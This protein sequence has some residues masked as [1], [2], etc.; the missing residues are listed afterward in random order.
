MQAYHGE[1]VTDARLIGDSMVEFTVGH[2]RF[3][4][5]PHRGRLYLGATGR[6]CHQAADGT[7]CFDSFTTARTVSAYM[8]LL[9]A[10]IQLVA[11]DP[12]RMDEYRRAR[13]QS[14]GGNP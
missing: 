11:R 3:R 9:G 4:Y 6:P 13:R 14:P 8:R 10:T 1:P 12:H 7:L 5:I 2:A